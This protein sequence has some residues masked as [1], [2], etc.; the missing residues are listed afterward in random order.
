L[1]KTRSSQIPLANH[2]NFV[3]SILSKPDSGPLMQ[4]WPKT[5]SVANP[6][7]D[8]IGSIKAIAE[9]KAICETEISSA[10]V[11]LESLKE[12]E[13]ID[14]QTRAK[15]S[16]LTA[17]AELF[18]NEAL[19]AAIAAQAKIQGG[20]VDGAVLDIEKARM[21]MASASN[22][23][24]L[25]SPP[26]AGTGFDPRDE[27]KECRNSIDR[28]DKLLVD[29]RKTGFTI[30]TGFVGAAALIFAGNPIADKTSTLPV[31]NILAIKTSVFGAIA[32]LILVV[33]F[34]DRVHAL[35]LQGA[36]KRAKELERI[37]GFRLTT[38]LS[39]D[40]PVL[41]AQF[42]GLAIYIA[43]L[44]VAALVFWYSVEIGGDKKIYVDYQTMIE[45]IAACTAIIMLVTTA[46]TVTKD[47]DSTNKAP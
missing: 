8:L 26:P 44:M 37:I 42:V 7:A 40:V 28:F 18:G 12:R 10:N 36:V 17:Q 29:L 1:R 23:S 5:G 32:L 14:Q 2:G 45:Q 24:S 31:E 13:K 11:F 9:L 22:L 6:R 34:I 39:R 15:L 33:F 20:D 43:F 27:W 41:L 38:D 16:G 35:W 30:M 46:A 21:A 4:Q 3:R 47:S 25:A 19:A